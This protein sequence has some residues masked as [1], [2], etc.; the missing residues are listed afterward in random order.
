M[1][2]KSENEVAQTCPTLSNPMDCSL[3][4]SSVHGI[5]QARVSEW[6]AIAFSEAHLTSPLKQKS[7]KLS[8]GLLAS[9][10]LTLNDSNR[11]I[12]QKAEPTRHHDLAKLLCFTIC[13]KTVCIAEA[14]F[15]RRCQVLSHFPS[16]RLGKPERGPLP[17]SQGHAGHWVQPDLSAGWTLIKAPARLS[18]LSWQPLFGRW[19]STLPT[20]WNQLRS[21]NDTD[22]R[23]LHSPKGF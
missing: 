22:P 17:L 3:P 20:Q 10:H 18:I 2:V 21:I 5:L 13:Q 12:S 14:V 7:Q 23:P 6:G 9:L 1:K 15:R 4:G 16:L 19:C 11:G 8:T